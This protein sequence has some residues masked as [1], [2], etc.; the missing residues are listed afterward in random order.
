MRMHNIVRPLLAGPLGICAALLVACGSSN[1]AYLPADRA[2]AL[3]SRLAL[4]SAAISNGN[5]RRAVAAA[6]RLQQDVATLPP[7]VSATLRANLIQGANTIAQLTPHDCAQNTTPTVTTTQ[8]TTTATTPTQTTPATTQTQT[9][10]TQTQP[11]T[12]P[13]QTQPAT[14]PNTTTGTGGA[15]L[16]NS[17][18]TGGGGSGNTGNTGQSSG[19]AGAGNSGP[20]NNG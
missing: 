13:T 3:N 12:T 11:A 20:G 2:S 8:S 4:I 10:P 5:C 19:G 18:N 1:S 16:G 17:G 15:G 6:A 14:T 9:T 7:L